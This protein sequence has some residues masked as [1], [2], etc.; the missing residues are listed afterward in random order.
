MA[1]LS[2]ALFCW[3][4]QAGQKNCP[5]LKKQSQNLSGG[6]KMELKKYSALSQKPSRQTKP[7]ICSVSEQLTPS[8]IVSLRQ[9]KQRISDYIQKEFADLALL[10]PP[11]SL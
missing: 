7:P 6:T 11:T 5:L 3:S 10:R 8:E 9:G 1:A 2:L 4:T